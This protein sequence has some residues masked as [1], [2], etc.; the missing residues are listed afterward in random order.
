MGVGAEERSRLLFLWVVAGVP[1]WVSARYSSIGPRRRIHER[2]PRPF[3]RLGL[4]PRNYSLVE[5]LFGHRNA[6]CG[7]DATG[8]VLSAVQSASAAAARHVVAADRHADHRRMVGAG[9]P[10][11]TQ[12]EPPRLTV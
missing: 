6:A 2:R 8:R 3:G 7:P 11:R 9:A 4:D 1:I 5:F 12:G 10:A